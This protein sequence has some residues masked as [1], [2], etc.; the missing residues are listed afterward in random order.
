MTVTESEKVLDCIESDTD[1]KHQV[2]M[3][4]IYGLR[5]S[6]SSMGL[7]SFLVLVRLMACLSL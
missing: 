3:G 5:L 1:K 2:T 7:L 4:D 6:A